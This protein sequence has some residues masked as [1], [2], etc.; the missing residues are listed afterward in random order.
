[1]DANYVQMFS[2][3]A[4]LVSLLFV[5]SVPCYKND[6]KSFCSDNQACYNVYLLFR[7]VYIQHMLWLLDPLPKGEEEEDQDDES[8]MSED[9][10]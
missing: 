4:L 9:V 7:I 10:E 3:N 1:M 2:G 5:E 8:S 6:Y